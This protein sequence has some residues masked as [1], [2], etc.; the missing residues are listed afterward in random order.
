MADLTPQHYKVLSALHDARAFGNRDRTVE[1][2]AG[3]IGPRASRDLGRPKRGRRADNGDIHEV[4]RLVRSLSQMGLVT[5]S[6]GRAK[7]TDEGLALVR[8]HP[9]TRRLALR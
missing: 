5:R 8:T 6:E 7:L 1:D 4:K 9:R 3:Q 2:I